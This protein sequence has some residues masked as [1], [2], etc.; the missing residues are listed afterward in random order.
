MLHFKAR[1]LEQSIC[2]VR[3]QRG[4]DC[5][6]DNI[7]D[8]SADYCS[9]RVQCCYVDI[10][11]IPPFDSLMKINF[12]RFAQLCNDRM[13]R[14]DVWKIKASRTCVS[15]ERVSVTDLKSLS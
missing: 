1:T 11:T 13:L 15:L 3:S 4:S 7:P 6:E 9:L 10:M 2:D 5:S 14:T 12:Q 8:S